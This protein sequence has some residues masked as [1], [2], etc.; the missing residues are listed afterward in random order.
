MK[1]M[2]VACFVF[3]KSIITNQP[4]KTKMQKANKT[5]Q[6]KTKKNQ[7]YKHGTRK[8]ILCYQA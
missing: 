8:I 6:N 1:K 4:K 3:T 7:N 2:M 5:K